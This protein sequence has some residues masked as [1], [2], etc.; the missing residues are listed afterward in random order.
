MP[1]DAAQTTDH[2]RAT[3]GLEVKFVV[4]NLFVSSAHKQTHTSAAHPLS[5]ADVTSNTHTTTA[6]RQSLADVTSPTADN[7]YN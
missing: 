3:D 7:S 2:R 5:L 6:H 4:L 1:S